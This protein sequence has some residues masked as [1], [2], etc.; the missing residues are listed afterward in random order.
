[1]S[2]ALAIGD[3]LSYA[4]DTFLEPISMTLTFHTT[5]T[6]TPAPAAGTLGVSA[7][8]RQFIMAADA[9]LYALATTGAG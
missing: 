7:G 1:M 5:S 2:I 4:A 6:A 3:T 9:N 8:S